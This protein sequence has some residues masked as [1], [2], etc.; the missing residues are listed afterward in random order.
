MPAAPDE[1]RQRMFALRLVRLIEDHA[2]QLS[3][4]LIRKL[5]N[6]D[7]C[8]DLLVSVPTHELKHRAYEIYRNVTD[9][10]LTKTESEI[11]ER[12]IGLGTRRAHQGVPYSQML[13]ALHA[14]KEHLWE[15]LRQEGFLEAR[16]LI[17]EIDLLYSLERFFD[18]AAYFAS[19][20][21]E[22]ARARDIAQALSGHADAR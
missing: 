4:G 16:D 19:V 7:A 11:E 9:W 22:S 1:G 14:T 3:E 8:S 15:F 20:G 12:Y 5:A 6:C 21:Y 17:G 10:L 18:R 2:D 13:Y